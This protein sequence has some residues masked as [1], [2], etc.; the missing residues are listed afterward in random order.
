MYIFIMNTGQ[1]GELAN[2]ISMDFDSSR[3]LAFTR[4]ESAGHGWLSNEIKSIVKTHGEI[5]IISCLPRSKIG[6]GVA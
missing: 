2:Q 5:H 6:A 4:P 3:Y 1:P